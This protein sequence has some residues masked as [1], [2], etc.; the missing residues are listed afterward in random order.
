[1]TGGNIRH[2]YRLLTQMER[3]SAIHLRE[4]VILTIV[5]AARKPHG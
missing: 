3:I 4:S 2:L 1:V 5:V